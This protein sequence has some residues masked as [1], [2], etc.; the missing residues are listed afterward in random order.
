[1]LEKPQLTLVVFNGSLDH[2]LAAFMLATTGAS[3]VMNVR[4]F[5]TFWGLN[6]LKNTSPIESKCIMHRMFN[7]I[8]PGGSQRLTLSKYNFFGL[9]T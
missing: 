1:M 2:A 6:I 9:G 8:N 4:M 3:M 5:F 7:V